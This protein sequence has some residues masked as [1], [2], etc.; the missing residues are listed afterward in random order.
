MLRCSVLGVV[1]A[2]IRMMQSLSGAD[3]QI[4]QECVPGTQ[5][6]KAKISGTPQQVRVCMRGCV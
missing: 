2:T 5:I 6:R 3:I 1:G 4:P